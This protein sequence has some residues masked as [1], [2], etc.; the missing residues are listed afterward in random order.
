MGSSVNSGGQYG[1]ASNTQRGVSSGNEMMGLLFG[2][3]NPS[4]NLIT[5]GAFEIFQR[6]SNLASSVSAFI[7]D[8]WQFGTS[9][10]LAA[11][12]GQQITDPAVLGSS[13]YRGL[14]LATT[15]AD[16]ATAATD[17]AVLRQ[18]VE[19]CNAVYYYGK[20]VTITFMVRAFR[21]GNFSF[22]VQGGS[23]TKSIVIPFTINQANTWETKTATFSIEADSTF[24]RIEGTAGLVVGFCLQGGSNFVAPSANQWATGGYSALAGQENFVQSTSD[25]F[26]LRD[27]RLNLGNISQP[28]SRAG[29]TFHGELALCQRHFEKSWA[30]DVN[31]GTN[32]AKHLAGCSKALT[33]AINDLVYTQFKVPKSLL[34]QVVLYSNTGISNR[35]NYNG[36]EVIPTISV[37]LNG[38]GHN[39]TALS[40]LT[41]GDA[42]SAYFHYTAD[43]E[44]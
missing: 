37:G 28:F 36:V 29:I 17:L 19:G 23:P 20:T 30:V 7:V 6:G 35:V 11:V 2:S 25:F 33:S 21:T 12:T 31:P 4:Q 22:F 42:V 18:K 8:R 15:T 43:S 13:S 9:G 39:S 40:G 26:D 16:A 34:P 44:L 32:D 14:R 38:F 41:V 24:N 10:S 27:V 3:G 5:N 1:I